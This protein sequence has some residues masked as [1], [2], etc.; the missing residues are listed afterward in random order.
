MNLDQAMAQTVESIISK[1]YLALVKKPFE[2]VHSRETKI[3][4]HHYRPIR[5]Q[6]Q[7]KANWQQR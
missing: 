1:R 4:M 6:N 3:L 7:Q 2:L 5:Q